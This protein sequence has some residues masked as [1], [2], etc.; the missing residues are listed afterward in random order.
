MEAHGHQGNI[1]IN[2]AGGCDLQSNKNF[3]GNTLQSTTGHLHLTVYKNAYS[4][5]NFGKYEC[6]A[7]SLRRYFEAL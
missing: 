7:P 2:S 3:L 5:L 1:F 4:L 6:S